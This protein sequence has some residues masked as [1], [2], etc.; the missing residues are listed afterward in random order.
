MTFDID[1]AEID[2]VMDLHCPVTD[3]VGARMDTVRAAYKE[4]ARCVLPQLPTSPEKSLAWTNLRQSLM[5]SIA[6]LAC[7]QPTPEDTP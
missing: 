1:D 5:F 4:L 2:R 6:A 3:E 7:N